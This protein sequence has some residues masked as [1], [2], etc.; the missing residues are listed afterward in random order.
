M[1]LTIPPLDICP[2]NKCWWQN[3]WEAERLTPFCIK[4]HSFVRLEK[5]SPSKTQIKCKYF[6]IGTL[7][8]FDLLGVTQHFSYIYDLEQRDG[9]YY[10]YIIAE[11]NYHFSSMVS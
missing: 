7:V 1:D 2:E 6:V 9:G 4:P 11:N 3:G 8:A 10:G 5:K